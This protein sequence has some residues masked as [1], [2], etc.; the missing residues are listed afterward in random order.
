MRGMDAHLPFLPQLGHNQWCS[1]ENEIAACTI[2]NMYRH[3]L[4]VI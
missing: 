3:D 4:S 1:V 2:Q